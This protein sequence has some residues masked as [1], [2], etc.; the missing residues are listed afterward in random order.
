VFGVDVHDAGAC[1]AEQPFV[2]IGAQKIDVLDGYGKRAQR[3]DAVEGEQ[4]TA[5]V[6]VAAD[7]VGVDSVA[8]EEM[9]RSQ[10][11][12]PRATGERSLDDLPRDR[13]WMFR[14]QRNRFH[15]A[16]D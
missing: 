8:A 9:A 10:R 13:A 6:K 7:G 3:L 5:C 16:F 15:A 4:D 14:P 1:R 12:E 2:R 11:D